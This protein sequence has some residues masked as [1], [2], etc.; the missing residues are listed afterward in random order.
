VDEFEDALVASAPLVAAFLSPKML[1]SGGLKVLNGG[2]RLG[3]MSGLGAVLISGIDRGDPLQVSHRMWTLRRLWLSVLAADA[4]VWALATGFD[5]EGTR[6]LLERALPRFQVHRAPLGLSVAQPIEVWPVS[7]RFAGESSGSW[8]REAAAPLVKR[9]A[10]LGVVDT[11]GLVN[12]VDVRV[13]GGTV[14]LTREVGFHGEASISSLDDAWLVASYRSLNHQVGPGDRRSH[15]A[16]WRVKDNPVSRFLLRDDNLRGLLASG[17]LD[18]PQPLVGWDN[19]YMA[20]AHLRAALAESSHDQDALELVFGRPLVER[21]VGAERIAGLRRHEGVLRR[22]ALVPMSATA[23]SIPQHTVTED[24]VRLVDAQ[25]R[26]VVGWCDGAVVATRYPPKRVFAA[27]A[28]RFQ[29][30]MHGLDVKRAELRVERVDLQCPPS[31]PMVDFEL[32]DPTLAYAVTTTAQGR[33]RFTLSS[34]DVTVCE[35]VTGVRG[36]DGR[37]VSYPAVRSSYPSRVRCVGFH[38]RQGLAHLASA[39][40]GTLNAHLLGSD[41]QVEVVVLPADFPEHP[42]GVAFVDRYVGGMGCA[43]ALTERVVADAL[44]WVYAILF[45]CSGVDGC[46]KCSDPRVVGAG[47]Q[48][49]QV[50]RILGA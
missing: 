44:S 49:R 18:P 45:G 13:W 30:P 22:S 5:G 42:A 10:T 39:L 21:L 37:V 16:L 38:Q 14:E 25:T 46:T 4:R 36:S 3:W 11:L 20:L 32:Q 12:A 1:S 17:R 15:P 19:P 7:P 43:E 35:T 33:L 2:D 50:L 47:P 9:G 29:V 26:A 34:W 31:T 27:G 48:K 23:T 8:I 24:V 41:G 28:H 40:Q 6:A